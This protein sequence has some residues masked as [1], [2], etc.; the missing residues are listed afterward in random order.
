MFYM[1]MDLNNN[2]LNYTAV[3]FHFHIINRF[4]VYVVC[5]P[6]TVEWMLF[7]HSGSMALHTYTHTLLSAPT[8]QK[9]GT[10]LKNYEEIA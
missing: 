1:E 4:C 10:R 5:A 2:N 6:P 3:F 8:K 7:F 9:P